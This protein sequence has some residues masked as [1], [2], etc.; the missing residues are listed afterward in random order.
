MES[1]QNFILISFLVVSLVFFGCEEAIEEAVILPLSGS[2]VLTDFKVHV[3][4]TSNVDTTVV[5]ISPID[6]I[7][8]AILSEN[9][10]VTDKISEYSVND[11][12]PIAGTITLDN[13][14]YARL[15]GNLPVNI[16]TKCDPIVIIIELGS[17]GEWSTGGVTD[18]SFSIKMVL[19]QLDIDGFYNY[20]STTK[21]MTIR[22]SDINET[23]TL[24]IV[25]VLYNASLAAINKICLPVTTTTE[26]TMELIKQD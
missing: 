22:Y 25:S 19:E 1:T 16:G 9:T 17:V 5:F 7:T 11:D 12:A 2:Y 10:V 3:F 13:D 6:G 4:S 20:D 23:D 14:G 26:R 8:S 24:G 21:H 18:S 15:T